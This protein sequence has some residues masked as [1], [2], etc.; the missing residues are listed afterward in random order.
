MSCCDVEM[1]PN[2]VAVSVNIVLE[3]QVVIACLFTLENAMEI[4]SFKVS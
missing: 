1:K 3:E 2:V 4:A